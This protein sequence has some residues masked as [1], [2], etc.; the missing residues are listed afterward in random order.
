M[1]DSDYGRWIKDK[2]L[3]INQ[4]QE[5]DGEVIFRASEGDI[6]KQLDLANEILK[7]DVKV[8]VIVPSDQAY[9]ARI[10]KLAHDRKVKVISY[11]R[12]IKDCYLDFYISFDNMQVGEM[13]AKY[14]TTVCPKGNYAILGGSVSDNNSYM[15][16]LGQLNILQPLVERGDIKIIY[17]QYV[18]NWSP[19]EG[20][21][22]MK[23][24]MD[25]H[26]KPDAVIAANDQLAEGAI[27]ALKDAGV[28]SLPF[29]S[30]QDADENACKRIIDGTQTMT[31][32]KP[33]GEIA[34]KAA[35]IAIQLATKGTLPNTNISINNGTRRVPTILLP[36]VIVNRETINLTVVAD[37]YL[38]EN[39]NI[40]E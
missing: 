4:I 29:I 40:S 30:G 38:K 3:F 13:Q 1:D 19:A 20:Y 32:Y 31:V 24:C 25:K 27:R 39:K 18:T 28:D 8:L 23:E 37:G 12:L 9:A 17:D 15:L 5:L 7:E 33:I 26:L 16:K 36:P 34:C 21:R 6:E 11:D 14:L 35:E 10:V 22:L 2:E